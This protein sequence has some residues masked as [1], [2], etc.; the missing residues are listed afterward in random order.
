MNQDWIGFLAAALRLVDLHDSA[1]SPGT[2]ATP[3]REERTGLRNG[4]WLHLGVQLLS[5]LDECDR[6]SNEGWNPLGPFYREAHSL[7]PGLSDEDILLVVHYLSTPTEI[8]FLKEQTEAAPELAPNQARPAGLRMAS[9]KDSALIERRSLRGQTDACRLTG[10]GRLA[11]SL[12]RAS[13]NWLYAHHDADKL[14]TALQYGE[15]QDIPLQCAALGQSIRR[16][17]HELTRVLEQ[18]GRHELSSHFMERGGQYLDTIRRVQTAVQHAREQLGTADTRERFNQWLDHHDETLL[19]LR[20][21][22][23]TLDE[24]MQAVERLSR[25]FSAFLHQVTDTHREVVGA[26]PFDQVA[27]AFALRPL[28]LDTIDLLTNS[29]GP[30]LPGLCFAAP[31]DMQG[32]L[33]AEVDRH[34]AIEARVFGE[35]G[36]AQHEQ[37]P[38]DW[39][40]E[41]H[42]DAILAA[43]RQGPLR[44]SK[45]IE[46]G[47]ARIDQDCQLSELV[48]LYSA[49]T[50]LGNAGRIELG[51]ESGSSPD[52]GINSELDPTAGRLRLSILPGDLDVAIGG[53]A[54]LAGDDIEMQWLPQQEAPHGPQ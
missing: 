49:P 45:A 53:R 54:W 16:F 36:D 2:V 5:Y 52:S 39:F 38:M 6:E 22:R 28:G 14:S 31:G 20:A 1:R 15:F 26:I 48:G 17:A 46:L 13:H 51:L 18:P 34:Q 41:Q 32:I 27:L 23:R 44:L 7:H 33:R 30:W 19:D 4:L 35:D 24:L 43:L 12:A 37:S 21:L 47:W 3:P 8:H 42:R 10:R 40:V 50:W 9:S 25:R 29:L 11:I